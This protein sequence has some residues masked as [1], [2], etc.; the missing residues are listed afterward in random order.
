MAETLVRTNPSVRVIAT[1]REPLKVEGNAST[2]CPPLAVPPEDTEALA[3]AKVL[4]EG[5]T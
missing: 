4:D 5:T 1:S 3:D 2:G